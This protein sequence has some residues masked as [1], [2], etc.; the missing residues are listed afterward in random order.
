MDKALYRDAKTH[1]KRKFD[2]ENVKEKR[3]ENSV[4]GMKKKGKM[5]KLRRKVSHGNEKEK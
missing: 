4:I 2:G 1:L 5:K 3:I